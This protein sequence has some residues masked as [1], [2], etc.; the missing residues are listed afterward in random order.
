MRCESVHTVAAPPPPPPPCSPTLTSALPP[1]PHPAPS[2]ST[3]VQQSVAAGP[4]NVHLTPRACYTMHGFAPSTPLQHTV[5][6]CRA[7]AQQTTH[8]WDAIARSVRCSL[9]NPQHCQESISDML[10][11]FQHSL[12]LVTHRGRRR[13]YKGPDPNE[14]ASSDTDVLVHLVSPPSAH[15]SSGGREHHHHPSSS[16]RSSNRVGAPYR[17]STVTR[18]R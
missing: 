7:E 1:F 10:P 3:C 15:I 13:R 16:Q 6:P 5:Y 12:G 4:L 2:C 17:D 9:R 18:R 11:D 8:S 14:R